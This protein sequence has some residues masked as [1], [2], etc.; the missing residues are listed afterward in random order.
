MDPIRR[1]AI[2]EL[3]ELKA[4][5]FDEA[6]KELRADA[7]PAPHVEELV[8]RATVLGNFKD[9]NA[10]VVFL[11]RSEFENEE[12]FVSDKLHLVLWN[13]GGVGFCAERTLGEGVFQSIAIGVPS[14]KEVD[15]VYECWLHWWQQDHAAELNSWKTTGI[16]SKELL[17]A[18]EK[19][20]KVITA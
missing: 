16:V 18:V 4:L 1:E 12:F 6:E 15:S 10:L 14:G 17:E 7:N 19:L 3:L 11:G 9:V 13:M 5:W 2:E 20:R 8:R